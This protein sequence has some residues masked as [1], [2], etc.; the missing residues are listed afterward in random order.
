MPTKLTPEIITAA[1]LGFQEQKRRIDTQIAELRAATPGGPTESAATPE[2]G[3]R[4]RKRFS[5]AARRKM[6]LAQKARWAKIRGESESQ[7]PAAPEAPKAK[8]RLSAHGR[9]AIIDATKKR[10]AAVN[11]AKAQQEKPAAKK[12]VPKRKLSPA[13]KAKLVANLAKPRA[14]KAKS[15]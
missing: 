4:K 8:R 14:A 10:W 6:A 2:T 12:T 1:I 11:A 15:V 5:A 7:S 9:K 13:A 3:A